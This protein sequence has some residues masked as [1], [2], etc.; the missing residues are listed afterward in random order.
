[1]PLHRDFTTD[2]PKPSVD[3]SPSFPVYAWSRDI[4]PVWASANTHTLNPLLVGFIGKYCFMDDLPLKGIIASST[5]M[6]LLWL[7]SF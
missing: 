4:Y 1:M 2:A 7:Y 5:D 3:F 6:S